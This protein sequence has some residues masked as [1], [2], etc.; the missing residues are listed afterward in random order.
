MGSSSIINIQRDSGLPLLSL[1]L[2]TTQADSDISKIVIL[3]TIRNAGG[4]DVSPTPPI[5]PSTSDTDG[6]FPLTVESPGGG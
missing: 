4:Q 2:I 5:H 6:I 3:N 1:P